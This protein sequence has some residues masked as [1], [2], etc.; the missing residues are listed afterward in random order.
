MGMSPSLS[1]SPE[2][3][4]YITMTLAS[5]RGQSQLPDSN[6]NF[7]R[8]LPLTSVI[9]TVCAGFPRHRRVNATFVMRIPD[10]FDL[11]QKVKI[12]NKGTT[13]VYTFFI[14]AFRLFS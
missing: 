11:N 10:K 5:P 14:F 6:S 12:R 7:S 9:Y 2:I 1:L 3:L 4:R 8:N 13:E